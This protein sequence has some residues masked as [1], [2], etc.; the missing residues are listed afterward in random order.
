MHIICAVK[1][2]ISDYK[3]VDMNKKLS[4]IWPN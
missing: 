2:H 3:H 1:M 4:I